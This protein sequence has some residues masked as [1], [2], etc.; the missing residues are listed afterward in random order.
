MGKIYEDFV[1][2]KYLAEDAATLEEVAEYLES[3]AKNFRE[4]HAAGVTLS[5]PVN[6]GHFVAITEDATVSSV[7]NSASPFGP[8][9]HARAPRRSSLSRRTSSRRRS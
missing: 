6:G 2:V 7:P 8:K 3:A 5:E 1:A 4:M 9:H